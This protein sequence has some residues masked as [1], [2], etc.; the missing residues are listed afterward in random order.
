[1]IENY[2]EIVGCIHI[3][4][5]YSD[6]TG[7]IAGIIKTAEQSGLDYI[8]MT[9][10]N[11]LKALKNGEER[12]YGP[13]LTIIGYEINDIDDANHYLA[14]GLQE[15]VDKNLPAP[16]YVRRVGK[17]G[18][19]GIIAHPDEKRHRMP[20]HPSYPWTA[21]DSE[22]FQGIEIWNQMSE[23]MEGLTPWNKLWRFI[24][25]RKSIVAPYPETLKR[26]DSVNRERK[27]IGIGGVDAHAHKHKMFGGLIR[28]TIFKYKVQFKSVRTHLLVDKSF[29]KEMELD[30]AKNLI[31]EA[32]LNSRA[33]V[34]NYFN[35]D[36]RGLRCV[37]E[38]GSEQVTLGEELQLKSNTTIRLDLPG[39]GV[40]RLIRNGQPV[41]E[42]EAKSAQF[43]VEEPGLYRFEVFR[44]K[45]AW[46]Y[47]NHIRILN[48]QNELD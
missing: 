5:V 10:H 25:P 40:M 33:Y 28:V 26:W 8:M 14:F 36:A 23:W 46:I 3:H 20:E 21:W 1:M 42:T 12:W 9:D 27:V 7:T 2:R 35:G 39:E 43:P 31:Y 47:T 30:H 44:N 29:K 34:S 32:I 4:S 41:V 19:F 11:N 15:E 38:N 17:D 48:E 24:N 45:R 6:G 16:E 13:V 37:A 18:G 22:E